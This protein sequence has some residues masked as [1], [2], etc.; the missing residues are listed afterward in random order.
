MPGWRVL[1]PDNPDHL[2]KMERFVMRWLKVAVLTVGVS[3]L[4]CQPTPS[5]TTA[6]INVARN[7]VQ[8][9]L[10]NWERYINNRQIDSALTAYNDNEDLDVAWSDGTRTAGM[11]DHAVAV[12]NFYNQIQFLNLGV[13]SPTINV[14]APDIATV[15]F[16]YSI[17]IQLND[18]SRDPYSGLGL[19]VWTKD[20]EDGLWRIQ[21]HV[22]TRN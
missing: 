5:L 13:Q 18:T 6:T 15:H 16:R 12:E 7:S 4:A 3:T 8:N 22:M 1:S 19:Q 11:E 21:N 2:K 14:I 17:D 10:R 20:A 9:Q